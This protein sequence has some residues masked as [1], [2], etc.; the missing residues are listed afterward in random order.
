MRRVPEELPVG[1]EHERVVIDSTRAQV[2]PQEYSCAIT[3]SGFDFVRRDE[4]ES[5]LVPGLG[6][7]EDGHSQAAVRN[8]LDVGRAW[9]A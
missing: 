4:A 5:V 3:R 1:A 8:A 9:L 7:A 6:L 2:A